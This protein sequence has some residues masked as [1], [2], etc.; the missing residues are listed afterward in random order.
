[1]VRAYALFR[2]DTLTPQRA[3]N[4]QDLLVF[5]RR[6]AGENRVRMNTI[7]GFSAP[8]HEFPARRSRHRGSAQSGRFPDRD[9]ECCR[10]NSAALLGLD[11]EIGR[12]DVG[13]AADIVATDDNPLD[14]IS[15][16][17][18][19][20]FVMKGGVTHLSKSERVYTFQR[21]DSNYGDSLLAR[22]DR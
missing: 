13:M 5:C 8:E 15:V 9:A 17:Q 11:D 21:V 6:Y 20:T 12:L 18:Q 19:I 14:D 7:P 10:V 1:L 16:L 2:C 3:K 22:L 4:C